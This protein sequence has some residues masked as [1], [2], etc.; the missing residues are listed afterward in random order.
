MVS[1]SFKNNV[2]KKLFIYKSY[3]FNI[4][5]CGIM[6][7]FMLYIC[8]FFCVTNI[9]AAVCRFYVSNHTEEL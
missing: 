9:F 2:T 8:N 3:I 7:F 4:Y 5:S 1:D 6:K